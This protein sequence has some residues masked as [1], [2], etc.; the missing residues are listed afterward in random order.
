MQGEYEYSYCL[1]P[2]D[3]DFSSA[4]ENGYNFTYPRLCALQVDKHDGVD[5]LKGVNMEIQ[6]TLLTTAV[7]KAETDN[8]VI[9]RMYNP[10][11]DV[12]IVSSSQPFQKTNLAETTNESKVTEC[13]VTPKKILTIKF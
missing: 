5:V 3:T 4:V 12:A 9:V 6:G 8:G 1:I 10:L 7:K 2:F 11:Q 13:E